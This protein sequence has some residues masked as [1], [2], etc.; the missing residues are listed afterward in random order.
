MSPA[1][2]PA[3]TPRAAPMPPHERRPAPGAATVPLLLPQGVDLTTRQIA[4]AAGIAEG[5]IFRVFPNKESLI[6]AVVEAALDSAPLEAALAAIDPELPLEPRLIAAV[7]ILR[8]RG[9]HR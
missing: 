8:R 2:A 5:T 4:E 7:E 3:R 9:A 1:A 6:D